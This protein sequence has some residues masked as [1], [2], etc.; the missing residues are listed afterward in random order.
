[1][2]I[3]LPLILF[4]SVSTIATEENLSTK[5]QE[6]NP[7]EF[8]TEFDR[9]T[10]TSSSS[11]PTTS[12]SDHVIVHL[13]YGSNPPDYD[14]STSS[15]FDSENEQMELDL[16]SQKSSTT[17]SISHEECVICMQR[18]LSRQESSSSPTNEASLS[19]S[20]QELNLT[21][22]E[23]SPIRCKQKC[24]SVFHVKCWE[25]AL[26]N[27]LGK[28]K[29]DNKTVEVKCPACRREQFT[30]IVNNCVRKHGLVFGNME[31]YLEW[32]NAMDDFMGERI[33]RG[34]ITQHFNG[35]VARSGRRQQRQVHVGGIRNIRIALVFC[36]IA[37]LS[38]VLSVLL[39]T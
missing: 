6:T 31:S 21:K 12:Q 20:I 36:V 13:P 7:L 5:N 23:L 27:E 33:L 22:Q 17:S 24:S 32:R 9:E 4:I 26:E 15:G 3:I 34:D 35:I 1:M 2:S 10:T 19:E 37:V 8:E 14:M 18:F 25:N 38:T 16:T 28:A 30:K 11:T 39:L 29:G